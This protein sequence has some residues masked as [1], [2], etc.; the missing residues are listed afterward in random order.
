[1][2]QQQKEILTAK[3]KLLLDSQREIDWLKRQIEQFE[4]EDQVE[5]AT[6]PQRF[7]REDFLAT[8]PVYQ[9]HINELR[10]ELDI[11][12]QYN[13]SKETLLEAINESHFALKALYPERTDHYDT[14]IK[15][16]T[17]DLINQRDALITQFFTIQHVIEEKKTALI[18]KQRE[19]MHQYEVNRETMSK[20]V[21]FTELRV[22][23]M[24]EEE[25]K[26]LRETYVVLSFFV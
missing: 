2:E 21:E 9:A 17:Q 25:L 16:L 26:G 18:E 14:E 20:I 8:Y 7:S 13:T 6:I 22:D 24:R 3:E 5:K 1:M 12:T 19:L 4:E 10:G 23:P 11:L 15:K